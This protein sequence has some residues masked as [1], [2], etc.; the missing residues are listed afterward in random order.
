MTEILH[1]EKDICSMPVWLLKEYLKELGG[2][3][4]GNSLVSGQGWE[5]Q[6]EP[7]ED[8]RVGSLSVGQVHIH[9]KAEADIF[10]EI[11]GAIEKKMLR[12]GG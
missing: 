5:M 10:S 11:Q 8:Y 7:M 2:T 12:A 9:L 6:I 3:T 1:W 4:T